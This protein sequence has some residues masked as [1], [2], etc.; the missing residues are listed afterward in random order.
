MGIYVGP[1][2]KRTEP[3]WSGPTPGFWIKLGLVA[4]LAAPV[5]PPN[6]A[7]LLALVIV[8]LPARLFED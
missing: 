8:A 2:K 5:L 3:R 6:L 4:N 1:K 7:L